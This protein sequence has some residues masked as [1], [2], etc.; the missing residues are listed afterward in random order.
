MWPHSFLVGQAKE[1]SMAA[2]ARAASA[3]ESAAARRARMRRLLLLLLRS[4][5]GVTSSPEERDPFLTG[6]ALPNVYRSTL[7]NA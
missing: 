4:E 5:N 2:K 1:R 7:W 3:E 6:V